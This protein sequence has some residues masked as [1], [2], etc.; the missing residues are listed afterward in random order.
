MVTIYDKAVCNFKAAADML[1]LVHSSRICLTEDAAVAIGERS[2]ESL[3]EGYNIVSHRFG[4][5]IP[6]NSRADVS[7]SKDSDGLEFRTSGL[8]W[9]TLEGLMENRSCCTCYLDTNTLFP[10]PMISDV[11]VRDFL[12]SGSIR[13]RLHTEWRIGGDVGALCRL[14]LPTAE[15]D[16]AHRRIIIHLR[17]PPIN[18]TIKSM[19]LTV[20]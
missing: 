8:A 15:E 20:I 14:D 16:I 13:D 9:I 7:V 1:M 19:N 4:I 11:F 10:S 2:K 3:K 6:E 17:Q 5:C 12:D 18:F